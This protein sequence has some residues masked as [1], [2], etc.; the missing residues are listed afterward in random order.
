MR[1]SNSVL[2]SFAERIA[3]ALDM[4]AF[5][6]VVKRGVFLDDNSPT[7]EF[8]LFGVPNAA[9]ASV[10]RRAIAAIHT[11]MG[12]DWMGS[13]VAFAHSTQLPAACQAETTRGAIFVRECVAAS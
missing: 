5:T 3:I 10:Q 12:D 6:F 1:I 4:P 7:V 8:H 2:K 13:V 11:I 9:C